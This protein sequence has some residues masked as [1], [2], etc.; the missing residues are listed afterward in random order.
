MM[1]TLTLADDVSSRAHRPAAVSVHRAGAA[2]VPQSARVVTVLTPLD[3][4]VFGP[5][6]FAD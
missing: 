2:S 4:A 5:A 3:L 6:S 1:A